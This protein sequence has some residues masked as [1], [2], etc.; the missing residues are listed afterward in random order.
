[1]DKLLTKNILQRY[2]KIGIRK[3]QYFVVSNRY[4]GG[5]QNPSQKKLQYTIRKLTRQLGFQSPR[6]Q[7][8]YYY[9]KDTTLFL[10]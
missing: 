2:L 10:T 7:T 3:V 4:G 8:Q 6:H 9:Q 1:M 5:P